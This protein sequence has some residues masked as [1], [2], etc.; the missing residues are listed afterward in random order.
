MPDYVTPTQ[1]ATATG[2]DLPELMK[3][4]QQD[5]ILKDTAEDGVIALRYLVDQKPIMDFYKSKGFDGFKA[6][7]GLKSPTDYV[8]TYK[9]FFSRTL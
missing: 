9:L 2:V 6:K 5:S 4:F 3:A 8:D 1:L 7:E